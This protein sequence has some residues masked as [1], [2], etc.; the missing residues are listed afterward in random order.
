MA[1]HLKDSLIIE[2]VNILPVNEE[3]VSGS[4]VLSDR[5]TSDITPSSTNLGCV[6][7]I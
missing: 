2:D 7:K 3:F 5:L 4:T 6:D 1:L